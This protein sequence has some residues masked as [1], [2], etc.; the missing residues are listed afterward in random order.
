MRRAPALLAAAAGAVVL[1]AL[2]A[3]AWFGVSSSAVSAGVTAAAL[4]TPALSVSGT[5]SAVSVELAVAAPASGVAPLSYVVDRTAPSAVPGLCTLAAPGPCTDPSPV[6]GATNT[7][8]VRATRHAWQSA[9][10][11]VDVAV[12]ADTRAFTLAPSTATPAAGTAFTVTITASETAYSGSKTL[13]WSGGGTV[14]P[15]APEYQTAVTFANG[16]GVATLTLYQAG[17]QALVATEGAYNGSASV[18]VSRAPVALA[19]ACPPSGPKG[20]AVGAT[21]SR[22]A[23]DAYGNAVTGA[24][25]VTVGATFATP[26]SQTVTIGNGAASQAFTVTLSNASNRT[27]VLSTNAPTGYT[28]APACSTVHA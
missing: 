26:A 17:A 22:P 10:A 14:G 21:L 11:S 18:T 13:V 15:Y 7:Y 6:A 20:T 2:P 5:P 12:P 16:V 24:V 27:T 4:G 25:A 3:W 8:A 9:P 19:L 1:L 23:A 28:A